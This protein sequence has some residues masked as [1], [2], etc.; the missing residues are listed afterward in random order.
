M[1]NKTVVKKY[2]EKCDAIMLRPKK[3]T[4]AAIRAAAAAD[5]QSVQAWILQQLA[6]ALGRA[7]PDQQQTTPEETDDIVCSRDRWSRPPALL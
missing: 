5:G 2:Q 6:P 3:E 7:A 1:S 4:G